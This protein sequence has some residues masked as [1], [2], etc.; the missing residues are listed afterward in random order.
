MGV[1][2]APPGA[3]DGGAGNIERLRQVGRV[4]LASL[5]ELD[6][7]RFLRLAMPPPNSPAGAD[8]GGEA[9]RRHAHQ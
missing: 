3:V 9:G 4:F 8:M 6:K 2:P 5:V 7:V 1:V